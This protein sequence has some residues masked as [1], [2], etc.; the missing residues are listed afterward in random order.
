MFVSQTHVL[1]ALQFK[2][3]ND[4]YYKDVQFN[5]NALASLPLISTDI[6][7]LIPHLN[8]NDAL[9]HHQGL[10]YTD[11]PLDS[12]EPYELESSSFISTQTNARTEVE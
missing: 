8:R 5:P 4:P 3:K 1:A 9:S 11:Q 6:S 2:M 12:F 10:S 7:P